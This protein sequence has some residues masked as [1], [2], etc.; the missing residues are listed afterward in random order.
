ML[1]VLLVVAGATGSASASEEKR[2]H[3]GAFF[4]NCRFSHTAGDDPIVYPRRPGASHAHTFF[5]N[6]STNAH[7]TLASLRAAG[8]TCRLRADTA[9]YWIPTL[10]QD[11]RPVRPSKAQFY[12]VMRGYENIRPLPSGLRMIA[13][14]AQAVRPQS[15]RVV[16]WACGGRGGVRSAPASAVPRCP[17]TLF[18]ELHVNYPDCWD[19]RRLDS[20]DHVSHVAHST[21]YRCPA[22]HPVKLPLIRLNVRYPTQGGAGVTL[23]SG[24]QLSGHADLFNA[25]D[26]AALTRLVNEC[27]RD[28]CNDAFTRARN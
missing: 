10:Y 7:S 17:Q 16:Y 6:V 5:G 1:T 4:S 18:L 22:S 15:H 11:G 19:G 24:G 25:W 13:G 28:R 27:F 21:N 20:P 23:A 9:A 12:Y 3:G 26:Q 14:N 8:T 2:L